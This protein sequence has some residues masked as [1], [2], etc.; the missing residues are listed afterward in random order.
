MLAD[1][2]IDKSGE[3]FAGARQDE[4]FELG[5]PIEFEAG[6][7]RGDPDL[8]HRRVGRDDETGSG[9]LE[10]DVQNTAL[11]LDFETCLLGF[12]ACVEMPLEVAERR[13][14]RAPEVLLVWH[15]HSVTRDLRRGGRVQKLDKKMRGRLKIRISLP[16]NRARHREAKMEIA[17]I[18]GIRALPAVKT[19]QGNFRP[20]EVFD[21]EG[22]ARPD[23][24][25]GQRG[26]R[27]ASGAEENDGA[28]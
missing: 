23:D 20:P 19:P 18:P 6:G 1:E 22:S 7:E 12:L 25:E 27:K 10:E 2:A 11:F 13:F 14:C 28:I 21:I 5:I 26:G 24:G 4:L 3:S 17:P 8:A 15:G 16:I 9:I